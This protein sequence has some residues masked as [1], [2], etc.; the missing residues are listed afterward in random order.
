MKKLII[1]KG[2]PASGKT[3]WAKEFIKN[4]QEQGDYSWVRINKDDFRR[5]TGVSY[6]FKNEN[7]IEDITCSSIIQAIKGGSNVISDDTN[8]NKERL[9]SLLTRVFAEIGVGKYKVIYKEFDVSFEEALKRDKDREYSVGKKVIKSFFQ[10]YFP[11]FDKKLTK[12]F[13]T[14]QNT[15]QICQI[16]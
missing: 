8:L 14:H 15:T 4:K 3:T 16:V 12:G 1:C 11:G 6:H 9:T 13:Q 10:R 2:V 7:F 5:S